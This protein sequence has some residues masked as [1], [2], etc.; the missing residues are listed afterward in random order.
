[1][2]F[3]A[4]D[5]NNAP[6]EKM[7]RWLSSFML[8]EIKHSRL[9]EGIQKIIKGSILASCSHKH[10]IEQSLEDL[11]MAQD[12][13]LPEYMKLTQELSK[14]ASAPE[15]DPYKRKIE[16]DLKALGKDYLLSVLAAKGIF[17]WLWLSYWHC[18]F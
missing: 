13:W 5:L 4:E 12:T 6:V 18:Y 14:L 3:F 16:F 9:E 2:V 15:A 10:I 17:A 8:F 1:V 11:K 7:S